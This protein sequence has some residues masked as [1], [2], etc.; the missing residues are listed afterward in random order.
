[1]DKTGCISFEGKKF[2]VGL[3]LLGRKVE[4]H[5]DPSWTSEVEIH[6]PEFVPFLV[7]E[8]VIGEHCGVRAELPERM[9]PLNPEGSRLLD[10]LN[11]DN[12]SG[13]TRSEIAVVFRKNPE[14]A[15]HV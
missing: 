2:E 8:Q 6:H 14:V 3:Q 4:V 13:R 12:I 15:A 1:M 5:Y 10:A 7:K 11:T 9:A